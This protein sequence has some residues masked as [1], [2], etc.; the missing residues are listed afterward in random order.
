MQK[1]KGDAEV[2]EGSEDTSAVS[3]DVEGER[4]DDADA[5][6][7]GQHHHCDCVE[8][9]QRDVDCLQRERTAEQAT[10]KELRHQLEEEKARHDLC[11]DW[12]KGDD[13]K[14]RYYTVFFHVWTIQSML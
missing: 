11:L 14:M 8:S 13:R 2:A 4:E 5:G 3:Q 10:V 6:T 12:F 9:L 7:S 1:R